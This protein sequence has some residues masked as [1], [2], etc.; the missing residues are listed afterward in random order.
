MAAHL[1]ADGVEK[2]YGDRMI[3]RGASLR[4]HPGDRVGLVGA[5]GCGKSTLLS[6]LAGSL[7]PTGGRVERKGRLAVLGQSPQLQGPTVRQAIDASVAWHRE[8]VQ[9][10]EQALAAGEVD[11]A[12]VLQDRLDQHGWEIDHK[13]EGM[14]QRV[15]APPLTAPVDSLSGGERRRVALAGCLLSGPD[16]LLL[17]EPTNH[18]D[19]E[20]V[21]WLEAYLLGFRG[22]LL[23][24]THDRYLL[25][26]VADRIVEVE[27]GQCVPYEGS[28]AD[29][30]IARAERQARKELSRDRL[31]RMVAQEAAWAARSPSARSTKQK[32]RL[33]RLDALREQVPTL[34]DRSFELDLSTGVHQGATLLEL[35]G[36][37]K[38]YDEPLFDGL[39]LVLR[40]GDRVGVLGPNGAG[41][42]TLLRILRGVESPDRGELLVGPKAK[43]GVLDQ[44]RTGLD[45]EATVF[46]AAGDGNDQVA[47]GDR[48]VHVASFLERFA[49]SRE[50]FDQQV[51]KLS[52]G[53]RARLLLARL[54]LQGA[55]V[56]LLDEPTNDLDLLT[57]R[58]LEEALLSY[59]G[60]VIVV[61]HDRAFLDRVA[62]HVLAF[63]GD[64]RTGHYASRTQ[65]IAAA[66]KRAQQ[67]AARQQEARPTPA[68]SK[69]TPSSGSKRLSYKEKQELAAL[70][71]RIDALEQE[72]AQ[73]EA[74]LGDPATYRDRA[75]EVP[76]LSA[77]AQQLPAEIEQLFERWE[78]LS[79]RDG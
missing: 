60:G 33:Q 12:A 27:D 39:D 32:A 40:P 44:Q 52:G 43:L 17:D 57:L 77:R 13:V 24:V 66:K 31:V 36:V 45:D 49:F 20:V 3:L 67:A 47:M 79:E 65:A 6:I 70:P 21:E 71:D 14:L 53:E 51:S 75:D 58:T 63:E 46:E 30:L 18:L 42:S 1:V 78:A 61:T 41:K 10:Y 59:D 29:Y 8:L 72:L 23:L 4:L 35:H 34:V 68:P 73:V 11:E 22:A 69:P 25:E 64:G 50:H 76:A 37:S 15:G 2:A 28:Y 26:A 38:A 16:L 55:T 48:W 5:N 9:R 62:T 19:A 56:L 7:E 54:M 74:T